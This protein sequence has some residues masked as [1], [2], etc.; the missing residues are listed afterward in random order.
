MKKLLAL[1]LALVMVMGLATVGTSAAKLDDYTD[2]ADINYDQA[3][4]VMSAIGVLEGAD[5]GKFRPTAELKRS[6]AAKIVAYLDRG[7]NTAQGLVGVGKFSDVPTNHWAAGYVDYLASSGVI[8]GKSESTFDPDGALKAID[9]AKMLLVVLGY[10]P[11]IEGLVG[12][13]Y[14]I[15]TSKLAYE[16][17]LFKGMPDV[18][19]DDVLTREQAA[20]MAFNAIKA[21]TVEYSNKGGEI[22]LNGATVSLGSSKFNYVTSTLA[23]ATNI[24]ARKLTNS[25][26]TNANSGYTVEF[27]EKAYPDLLLNETTDDFGRPASEWLFGRV[28]IGEYVN[29]DQLVKAYTTAVTGADLFNLLGESK[30]KNC[31]GIYYMVN[32]YEVEYEAFDD[33]KADGAKLDEQYRTLGIDKSNMIRSNVVPYGF[34]GNGV[35]TEVYER[36]DVYG[37]EIDQIIIVSIITYYAKASA[38]YNAKSD[39][40]NFET[41]AGALDNLFA[42]TVKNGGANALDVQNAVVANGK[43]AARKVNAADVKEAA[44]IK[45]DDQFLVRPYWDGN[46]TTGEWRIGEIIIPEIAKDVTVTKYSTKDAFDSAMKNLVYEGYLVTGGAQKD[47]S[48]LVYMDTEGDASLRTYAKEGKPLDSNYNLIYDPYGY[49]IYAKPVSAETKYVFVTGFDNFNSNL[50]TSTADAFAIFADGTSGNIKVNIKKTNEAIDDYM[51]VATAKNPGY[52]AAVSMHYDHLTGAPEGAFAGSFAGKYHYAYNR[53]FT[54][55]TSGEGASAVYTLKPVYTKGTTA[56]ERGNKPR[57]IMAGNNNTVVNSVN[58]NSLYTLDAGSTALASIAQ[59]GNN[60]DSKTGNLIISPKSARLTGDRID[61]RTAAATAANRDFYT[62]YGNEKS[63]FITVKTAPVSAE[64]FYKT[65]DVNGDAY[66]RGIS[67]VTGTYTGLQSIDLHTFPYGAVASNSDSETLSPFDGTVYAVIDKND[68][69]VAAIIVGEDTGNSDNYIYAVS[70]A[71][72]QWKEGSYYYWSFNAI[73]DGEEKVLT[74]KDKFSDTIENIRLST[75][76]NARRMN[77]QA[78]AAPEVAG[79]DGAGEDP[80][81]KVTFDKDGFITKATQVTWNQGTVANPSDDKVYNNIDV[82]NQGGMPAALDKEVV[83]ETYFMPNAAATSWTTTKTGI[84]DPYSGKGQTLVHYITAGSYAGNIQDYRTGADNALTV[85]SG[86]PIYVVQQYLSKTNGQTI[87]QTEKFST[88]DAAMGAIA[89]RNGTQPG[90]TDTKV[91]FGGY[92]SAAL[93]GRG[94][95][96]WVVL[97]NVLTTVN[98]NND[99]TPTTPVDTT[100]TLSLTPAAVATYGYAVTVTNLETGSYKWKLY[101]ASGASE[102]RTLIDSGDLNYNSGYYVVCSD[103]AAVT[104]TAADHNVKLVVTHNTR[105]GDGSAH[106]IGTYDTADDVTLKEGYNRIELVSALTSGKS[107][108]LEILKGDV[109]IA[110]S[111]VKMER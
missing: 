79:A 35:L 51:N 57:M 87:T 1:V 82:Y 17:E 41:H 102:G 5:D 44:S 76:F 20:Q 105:L 39:T 37:L 55:E 100:I 68:Y 21:A 91:P 24:S 52:D 18:K 75:T 48:K 81:F 30:I 43:T 4:A 58:S 103:I 98:L 32:G 49:V 25:G 26:L 59:A 85:L 65:D 96:K 73:V 27:G 61:Y 63:V 56:A 22:S 42:P 110:Q 66:K 90:S 60:F 38:D 14:K 99:K 89:D 47:Y 33:W 108:Q 3:V 8:A 97:K 95:A 62:G 50:G 78:A 7:N 40:L 104:Y 28:K 84:G 6:E 36:K 86:A 72:S 107:Y 13:D 19:S 92:I 88:F 74:V 69:I 53:W 54:Y 111:N 80:M 83:Y 29:K 11:K 2:K 9:F 93:D 34:T 23:A 12:N 106:D 10:D 109:V 101:E 67:E 45:K 70:S 77:N 15:N 16:A 64:D 71:S 46:A 94:R 31:D